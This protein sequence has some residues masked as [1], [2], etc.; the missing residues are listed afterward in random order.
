MEAA[1]VLY[2]EL[3]G[4]V[5]EEADAAGPASRPQAEGLLGGQEPSAAEE[6]WWFDS[7]TRPAP[8]PALSCS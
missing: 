3:M 8:P 7:R 6:E 5:E 4:A 1:F 2:E